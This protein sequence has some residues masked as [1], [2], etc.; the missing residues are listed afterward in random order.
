MEGCAGWGRKAHME[1]F[2]AIDHTSYILQSDTC[3]IC[4]VITISNRHCRQNNGIRN[5]ASGFLSY[6]G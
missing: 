3:L 6:H 4:E 2:L 1:A 5:L